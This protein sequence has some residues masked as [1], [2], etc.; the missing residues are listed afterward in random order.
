VVLLPGDRPAPAAATLEDARVALT[1]PRDLLARLGKGHVLGAAAG[2]H[3]AG[4]DRLGSLLDLALQALLQA[5]QL[6]ELAIRKDAARRGSNSV[7]KSSRAA[8]AIRPSQASSTGPAA[9]AFGV[10]RA[11]RIFAT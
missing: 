4:T 1:Q 7:R 6:V 5:E 3:L 9:Y 2:Q 10:R 8:K 11:G